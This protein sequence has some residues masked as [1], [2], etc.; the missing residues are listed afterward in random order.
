MKLTPKIYTTRNQ[1]A[2]DFAIGFLG[3]CLINALLFGLLIYVLQALPTDTQDSALGLVLLGLPLL[4]NV[5]ALIVLGM[6]RRWI[7][8]GALAA[9]ALLLVGALLVGLFIYAV[10]YNIGGL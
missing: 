3:W 4:I 2:L 10:C 7:A 1:K 6:T 8:L 9:F 5:T